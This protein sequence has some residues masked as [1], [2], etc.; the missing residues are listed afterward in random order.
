MC[1]STQSF[2]VLLIVQRQ[3]VENMA[4]EEQSGVKRRGVNQWGGEQRK[5]KPRCGGDDAGRRGE[6]WTRIPTTAELATLGKPE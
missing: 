3:P 2:V 6:T 4:Q 5:H 1:Q